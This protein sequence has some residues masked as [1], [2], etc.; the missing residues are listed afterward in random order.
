MNTLSLIEEN[1]EKDA[2]LLSVDIAFEGGAL[3]QVMDDEGW[4]QYSLV[5]KR[6]EVTIMSTED[7]MHSSDVDELARYLNRE[8][9]HAF[10]EPMQPAFRVSFTSDDT[11]EDYLITWFINDLAATSKIY[12]ESAIGVR[13]SAT[14]ESLRDFTKALVL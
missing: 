9:E 8:S 13:F 12:G 6:D 14:K 4:I 10:F 1:F 7:T 5:L 2:G 3:K 11:Q